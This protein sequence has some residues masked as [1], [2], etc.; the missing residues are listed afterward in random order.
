MIIAGF[1][2]KMGI[3]KDLDGVIAT[4]ALISLGSFG[5]VNVRIYADSYIRVI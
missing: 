1:V 4:K 5:S 3:R 2:L